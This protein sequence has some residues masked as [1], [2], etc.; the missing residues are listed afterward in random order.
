MVRSVTGLVNDT[1]IR[2]YDESRLQPGIKQEAVF[3]LL[4]R[5]LFYFFVHYQHKNVWFFAIVRRG[6]C[7][8][9][10]GA[11]RLMLIL[12][13]APPC[14]RFPVIAVGVWLS[15]WEWSDRHLAAETYTRNIISGCAV[16]RLTAV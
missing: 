12:Q 3:P 5:F 14:T 7:Y 1:A 4:R 8:I 2:I 10:V 11:T 9:N 13:H 15:L 6:R 16:R